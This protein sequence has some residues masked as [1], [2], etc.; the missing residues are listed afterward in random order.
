MLRK[1]LLEPGHIEYVT[2]SSEEAA[3]LVTNGLHEHRSSDGWMA[4]SR[5]EWDS[6]R[7]ADALCVLCTAAGWSRLPCSPLLSDPDAAS[8]SGRWVRAHCQMSSPP[9]GVTSAQAL[10][11]QACAAAWVAAAWLLAAAWSPVECVRC[12][13]PCQLDECLLPS[14]C[15]VCV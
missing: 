15:P 12:V 7:N 5:R 14:V 11:A 1:E 3:D 6:E 9:P 4:A 13:C 10:A 2:T 8:R